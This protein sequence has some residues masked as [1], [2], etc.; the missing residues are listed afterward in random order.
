MNEQREVPTKRP[1]YWT[2]RKVLLGI[3]CLISIGDFTFK[4][5]VREIYQ[6]FV[7]VCQNIK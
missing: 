7:F 3:N 2:H 1:E 6:M 4:F 5:F